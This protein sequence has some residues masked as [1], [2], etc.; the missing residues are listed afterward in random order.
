MENKLQELTQKIYSEGIEKAKIDAVQIIEEAQQ[1]ADEI[2]RNAQNEALD[3][4]EKAKA[5][6]NEI[7]RNGESE[8]RIASKQAISRL[9]QQIMEMVSMKAIEQPVRDALK[10]KQFVGTLIQKV[11]ACFNNNAE[12]ILPESD[13]DMLY[14]Y[15]NDNVQKEMLKGIQIRFDENLGAGFKISPVEANYVISFTDDDFAKYFK[16]FMR[17]KTV[18]LLFGEE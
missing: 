6:A 17:P 18:G 11:A 13:K 5:N 16:S 2:T 4:I 8:I 15:F 3:I 1:K 12:I 7:K 9:K 14:A 10:D